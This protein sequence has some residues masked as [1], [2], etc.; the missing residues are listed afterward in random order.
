MDAIKSIGVVDTFMV[1]GEVQLILLTAGIG[2]HGNTVINSIGY[3]VVYTCYWPCVAVT[4][5]G[6]IY[7][8]F[9]CLLEMQ[10][11]AEN[12][13][14]IGIGNGVDIRTARMVG[15]T[16]DIPIEGRFVIITNI[17][18]LSWWN[19]VIADGQL[20]DN[21]TIAAMDVLQMEQ[22]V[23][24]IERDL[25]WIFFVVEWQ[26][27]FAYGHGMICDAIVGIN[28]EVQPD[29]AVAAMNG[30]V[31]IRYLIKARR[32]VSGAIERVAFTETDGF[33]NYSFV[34]GGIMVEV[35]V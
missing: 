7:N 14:A 10:I 19:V 8:P 18:R 12:A 21:D 31:G 15:L 32:G 22:V 25:V 20:N 13:F 34:I 9:G 26:L 17:F 35:Q 29:Y 2:E 6:V 30:V 28:G 1:D 5:D 24:G 23:T 27:A 33:F 4:Y 16:V 11:E 3:F